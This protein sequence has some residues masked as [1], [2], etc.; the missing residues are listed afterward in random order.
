MPLSIGRV[1]PHPCELDCRRQFVDEPIAMIVSAI[2]QFCNVDYL[3][4]D[5]EVCLTRWQTIETDEETLAAGRRAAAR[6]INQSL[7]QE[8]ARC[9]QWGLYCYRK[10]RPEGE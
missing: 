2:G 7:R 4:Q 8:A 5:G 6:S 9:L 10:S 1:C 3:P